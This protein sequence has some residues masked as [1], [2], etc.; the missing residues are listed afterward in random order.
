MVL[1]SC[2]SY[3]SLSISRIVYLMFIYHIMVIRTAYIFQ[4]FLYSQEKYGELIWEVA[5]KRTAKSEIE[6][7]A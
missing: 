1:K 5:C 4:K 2:F 3:L 7:F 6:G